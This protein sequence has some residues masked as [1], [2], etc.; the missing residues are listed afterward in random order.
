[1]R[2]GFRG[3]R[4]FPLENRSPA[5]AG[6]FVGDIEIHGLPFAMAKGNHGPIT[7][8]SIQGG[9]YK[10]NLAATL[11]AK[12]PRKS[13]HHVLQ[14]IRQDDQAAKFHVFEKPESE[15]AIFLMTGAPPR[16]T[17]ETITAGP[18][19]VAVHNVTPTS[20]PLCRPEHTPM[21]LASY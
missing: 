5:S 18:G 1:M 8:A 6:L 4:A 9:S 15:K 14:L 16:R 19:T 20:S 17:S 21:R 3:P 11:C 13:R 2:V 7:R 10:F 12:R